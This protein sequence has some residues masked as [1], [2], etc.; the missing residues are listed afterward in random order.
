M[1]HIQSQVMENTG[2]DTTD[3]GRDER[4]HEGQAAFPLAFARTVGL[5]TPPAKEAMPTGTAVL[6]MSPWGYEEMCTRKLWRLLAERFARSGVASL[7][8]D[9]PGTG[10]A[11]DGPEITGG[12]ALWE[13]AAAMAAGRLKDF[14]DARRLIVVGQ[15]LGAAL[16]A[17]IAGRLEAA[18]LVLMAPVVSGRSYLRELSVWS[19]MV[20]EGLGLAAEHRITGRTSVAGL[21]M[22]EDVAADVGR[23]N[24]QTLETAPSPQ[25]LVIE[26][27]DRDAALSTHLAD[28]G[29]IVERSVYTGFDELVSNPT[30]ARQP[31]DVIE[32]VSAWV[33][34][35]ARQPGAEAGSPTRPCRALLDTDTFIE[36][37]LRFGAGE[38]LFGTICRPRT[39]RRGATVILLGTAYDRQAG[40]ACSTVETA[41]HLAHHGIA[42]FRFDAANVGDSPPVAGAPEQVQY[43]ETQIDDA[44]AALDLI[45]ARG[46]AP[47][48]FAGRCSGAY[49]AFRAA[50]ADD[51]CVGV[52]AVNP[53]TLRWDPD[54][55]VDDALRYN[56]R[57]LGDYRR[58]AFD[59][60]NLRRLFSGKIDLPNAAANIALQLG[61]RIAVAAPG[62]L[63]RFSRFARLRAGT[64]ADF[65]ALAVRGTP[66]QL[67]YSEGDVGL[68]RYRLYFGSRGTP[69]YGNVAFETIPDADHNLSP[70]HAQTRYREMLVAAALQA[71]P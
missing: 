29:T 65:R 24:L 36:E 8:F 43:A 42:S 71:A 53:F 19:K 69:A 52:V 62:T 37:P 39:D 70:A 64:H 35:T 21:L 3:M 20:D 68:E 48:M 18:G 6:L 57:S 51:R 49:L 45:E 32:R 26:R 23:L 11:L 38:H 10:D 40:W 55:S 28:L 67:I 58:R 63:G 60:G 33:A 17:R 14:S 25:T 66:V 16:A 54:E 59:P 2:G 50:I 7:R 15:G 9:Y 34:D 56:P 30:L 27:T 13:D 12:L 5:Y 46:L 1:L 22:P 41:R 47:A 4:W 61:R 44:K 31:A